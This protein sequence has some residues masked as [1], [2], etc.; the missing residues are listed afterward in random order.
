LVLVLGAAL[1]RL[2]TTLMPGARRLVAAGGRRFND[3]VRR[4]R[5]DNAS[6]LAWYVLVFS[7][8]L[9]TVAL[10]SFAPLLGAYIALAS[11]APAEQLALLAPDHLSSHEEYVW[12]LEHIV[13]VSVVGW[14][15]VV[16]LVRKGQSLHWGLAA[17]GVLVAISAI[18]LAHFPLRHVTFNDVFEAVAWNDAR[19][20]V[21]GERSDDL[22]LFCPEIDLPRNR[23]VRKTD[24]TVVRLGLTENI[25]TRFGPSRG[26]A[27]VD[28]D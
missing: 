22:L 14:I 3:I 8:G 25:F 10:V 23:I 15:P 7:G 2:S 28:N 9:L 21:I 19:C 26:R 4:R 18:I 11:T 13:A 27:G 1:W 5:L 20:Y 24:D 16:R 6:V 12:W 17:G